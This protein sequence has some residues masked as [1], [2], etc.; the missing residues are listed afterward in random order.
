MRCSVAHAHLAV[1]V[2]LLNIF[3]I[4]VF[5]CKQHNTTIEYDFNFGG[6]NFGGFAFEHFFSA[7]FQ[8]L[9]L[10]HFNTVFTL[11]CCIVIV[12]SSL[13]LVLFIKKSL[14][15]YRNLISKT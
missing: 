6:F 2:A 4:L 7:F 1:H 8:L 12:F 5:F 15:V 11:Y 3:C 13:P 14:V 10:L 9:F